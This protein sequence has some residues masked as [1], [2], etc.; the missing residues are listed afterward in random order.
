MK[1]FVLCF[2]CVSLVCAQQ[3][4]KLQLRIDA[5][6]VRNQDGVRS[7]TLHYSLENL[8]DRPLSFFLITGTILP[9]ASS[10]LSNR[11]FYRL[12]QEKDLID[13]WG[14]F[15]PWNRPNAESTI[16]MRD[17]TGVDEAAAYAKFREEQ[18]QA[19]RNSRHTIGPGEILRFEGT[20]RWD[21]QRYFQHDDLEYYLDEQK[22]HYIEI[23]ITLLR[24]ELEP[25][26]TDAE[27]QELLHDPTQT[28]GFYLSNRMPLDFSP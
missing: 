27:F 13:I 3:K 6:D 10:S 5:I 19:V 18:K 26:F 11:P 9:N 24:D 23:G 20:L 16:Q 15:E 22:P 25:Y 4:E 12:Y 7:F 8:T 17:T 21:G 28:R 14:I 1:T 2:L